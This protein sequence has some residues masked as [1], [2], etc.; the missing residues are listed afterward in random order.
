M[1]F[2]SVTGRLLLLV[3]LAFIIATV[4]II[5]F[6]GNRVNNIIDAN[7]NDVYTERLG[8]IVGI[9]E[10]TNRRL[11]ST[12]LVE[13]YVDVF[14]ESAVNLL[15]DTY[16]TSNPYDIYPTIIDEHH[17][18][19]ID[20]YQ[21]NDKL[22]QPQ[23]DWQSAQIDRK[24]NQCCFAFTLND[25]WY[26]YTVF[27]PWKWRIFY[28]IP[29]EVKY[30]EAKQLNIAIAM[31]MIGI[32]IM[33]LL[34]LASILTH[35]LRPIAELTHLTSEISQGNFDRSV[36][37]ST[38]NEFGSLANSFESMR[39][40]INQQIKELE[41]KEENLRITLDSIGDGVI[42]T[43]AQGII[44]R[45]NTIASSLTG[46][47]KQEAIGK[48]VEAVV[49]LID[50]K[51][52]SAITSP[53]RNV[54]R[55][56]SSV[57]LVEGVVLQARNVKEYLISDS[58]A[59]IYSPDGIFMGVVMV[60]RDI[61]Q[62]WAM[63]EQFQHDR[64]MEAIGQLAGGVAH[65]FNN[66]LAGISGAT[67]LL[68]LSIS[69]DPKQSNLLNL[70]KSTTQRAS[71]LTQ[72]LLAFSRKGQ[73]ISTSINIHSIIDEVVT[74]LERSIDKRIVIKKEL[75]A[76]KSMVL[77]DPSQLQSGIL[78]LCLN[79]RDAMPNG[80][81]MFISTANTEFDEEYCRI[82]TGL[83]PNTY[84]Q[85]SI[86]DTGEGMPQ[87]IQTRIFEPFFTT[88]EVGRGTGLGLPAVYGMVKDH[89]GDI[90]F[91]SE[92]GKGTVFYIYLPV[93]GE[94]AGSVAVEESEAISG[95]GTVLLI[96]DEY[97]IRATSSL[98]L[99]ELGYTVL[100]AE[101]G[102]EGIELYDREMAN[103]DLVILDMVMPVMDGRQTFEH[104][105]KLNPQAKVIMASGFARN[106]KMANMADKGLAGFIMKPFNRIKLS[107]LIADTLRE[108][109]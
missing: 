69:S 64:R 100:L 66:M 23:V 89:R 71:G 84:V 45:I 10:R 82:D 103:I 41:S 73:Y 53:V 55:S 6:A 94:S 29:L 2:R 25:R 108:K 11:E 36:S 40:A 88:K 95:S 54:I 7:Q 79:A 85:I 15:R 35:M 1:S 56:G 52:R 70:I 109:L 57:S 24:A 46:W 75:L 97:I 76:R 105:K 14:K 49:H 42:V 107:R 91:Y 51:D 72:K 50:Y 37:I 63:Q 17:N 92:P 9:L 99:Q 26:I 20:R 13:A 43:D 3:S 67:E 47:E 87:E 19:I 102:Q 38:N 62:E 21:P 65:D 78:N 104:I 30:H 106:L 93:T 8:M 44:T 12:G 68:E 4:S 32:T 61:T 98:L 77:G 86:Q 39:L 48:E 90:R 74:I 34:L 33:V 81:S 22:Y 28:S 80:G 5:F 27:S 58:A 60:F 96:D 16:Y 59:P 101:N 83:I 18:V 31:I